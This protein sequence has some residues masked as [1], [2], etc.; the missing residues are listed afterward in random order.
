MLVSENVQ[1]IHLYSTNLEVPLVGGMNKKNIPFLTSEPLIDHPRNIA[2]KIVGYQY[3]E[4]NQLQDKKKLIY[5]KTSISN[6]IKEQKR[7]VNQIIA[8]I[9]D[10]GTKQDFVYTNDE[11]KK[12]RILI[13]KYDAITSILLKNGVDMRNLEKFQYFSKFPKDIK[14]GTILP[15]SDVVIDTIKIMNLE[16][17]KRVPAIVTYANTNFGHRFKIYH[18]DKNLIMQ[19]E[20]F[21]E[22][23]KRYSFLNLH[24]KISLLNK[25]CENLLQGDEIAEVFMESKNKEHIRE[26]FSDKNLLSDE[27]LN[28]LWEDGN[29]YIFIRNLKNYD[30]KRYCNIAYP[31]IKILKNIVE[32]NNLKN[33]FI[34]ALAYN[35]VKHSPAAMYLKAGC[36]P[37]S[38]TKEEIMNMLKESNK[39]YDKSIFFMYKNKY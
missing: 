10:K 19:N 9:L 29:N 38:H 25:K 39:A 13:K 21:Q 26:N 37:I 12:I 6:L 24:G 5:K 20:K 2:A 30:R 23:V 16:L 7:N 34:N 4:E 8:K 36:I 1:K 3:S 11:I 22:L 33:V 32:T 31:L 18:Y 28:E 15:N 27:K 14:A 35:N 17:N